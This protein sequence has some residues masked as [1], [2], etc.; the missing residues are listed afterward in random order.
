MKHEG[1]RWR[2]YRVARKTTVALFIKIDGSRLRVKQQKN[3]AR[4]YYCNFNQGVFLTQHVLD[5][6]V[7][8]GVLK[9]HTRPTRTKPMQRECRPKASVLDE[10]DGGP[11]C[12]SQ[13][14]PSA[15]AGAVARPPRNITLVQVPYCRPPAPVAAS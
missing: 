11:L 10:S 12:G 9:P 1:D 6:L 2:E 4:T 5:A 14:A 7:R 15:A 13:V 3:R 8:K